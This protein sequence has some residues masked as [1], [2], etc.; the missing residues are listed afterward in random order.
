M[1]C[2]VH[3]HAVVRHVGRR[4]GVI[5]PDVV[6]WGSISYVNSRCAYIHGRK[7]FI[8]AWEI[9]LCD[10]I[11]SLKELQ[12]GLEGCGGPCRSGGGD[13]MW[14][15]GEYPYDVSSAAAAAVKCPPMI[16]SPEYEG[17]AVGSM[18]DGGASARYSVMKCPSS[19]LRNPSSA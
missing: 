17:I 10:A 9:M 3:P 15:S 6:T 16:G 11:Q 5:N 4:I 18:K 14:F 8:L 7:L 19:P 2:I 1:S 13:C 12:E